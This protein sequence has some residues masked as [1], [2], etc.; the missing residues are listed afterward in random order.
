MAPGPLRFAGLALA[1]GCWLIGNPLV[2]SADDSS[3][4]SSG[5]GGSS[6]SVSSS[7]AQRPAVT[8]PGEGGR[9]RSG[10]PQPSQRAGLGQV[11][12]QTVP[13]TSSR[14]AGP[15]AAAV[16]APRIQVRGVDSLSVQVD[17]L[18]VQMV[19]VEPSS[20]SDAAPGPL[21]APPA[22][23]S[24]LPAASA[25][26]VPVA[27]PSAVADSTVTSGTAEVISALPAVSASGASAAV[28]AALVGPTPYA[29]GSFAAQL[30]ADPVGRS[31]NMVIGGLFDA[32]ANWVSTLPGGGFQE[33]LAG[34]L[35]LARRGWAGQESQSLG[36]TAADTA[37]TAAGSLDDLGLDSA[38]VASVMEALN[39]A[40][41]NADALDGAVPEALTWQTASMV[42]NMKVTT[43][44]PGVFEVT[45]DAP[46][47][48]ELDDATLAQW[49]IDP[50]VEVIGYKVTMA[51]DVIDPYVSDLQTGWSADGS[52]TQTGTGSAWLAG[53][54]DAT[55]S[56][57]Y[58]PPVSQ[59]FTSSGTGPQPVPITVQTPAT[60][61]VENSS[62]SAG[63]E[64]ASFF[65]AISGTTMT[66]TSMISG[67]RIVAGASVVSGPPQGGLVRPVAENTLITG[68]TSAVGP[69]K[70]LEGA[71]A[72]TPSQTLS[73][74]PLTAGV[75]GNELRIPVASLHGVTDL[76]SLVGYSVTGTEDLPGATVAPGTTITGFAS[77]DGTTAVFTVSTSNMVRA[78]SLTLTAPAG[79][80]VTE[81]VFQGV[82]GDAAM[83][84]PG[85]ALQLELSPDWVT[86]AG[87]DQCAGLVGAT[88]S[89]SGVTPATITGYQGIGSE[90]GGT[91]NVAVYQISG[92]PQAVY[93]TSA[94]PLLPVQIGDTPAADLVGRLIVGD[95]IP[96]GTTIV[97]VHSVGAAGAPSVFELSNPVTVAADTTVATV[98]AGSDPAG[99]FNTGVVLAQV[100]VDGSTPIG[101]IPG[102]STVYTAPG[103]QSYAFDLNWGAAGPFNCT[104]DK[105]C[106][107]TLLGGW[108]ASEVTPNLTARMQFEVTPV[109]SAALPNDA[110]EGLSNVRFWSGI[111]D[112][113]PLAGLFLDPTAMLA[114]SDGSVW[115]SYQRSP[116]AKVMERVLHA[117]NPYAIGESTQFWGYI[118]NEDGTGPGN[119]LTVTGC[120][121]G[122]SRQCDLA[123]G[124]TVR[125]NSQQE[126]TLVPTVTVDG[127]TQTQTWG[128]P[129]FD[130]VPVCSG[131]TCTST[132]T[133]IVVGKSTTSVFS[134]VFGIG[135]G[136]GPSESFYLDYT[137][138]A[139]GSGVAT[140]VGVATGS[141]ETGWTTPVLLQ[142][143]PTKLRGIWADVTRWTLGAGA[144]I[145]GN[146][147]EFRKEVKTI[148]D[149]S[150]E[151]KAEFLRLLAE[152]L[153]ENQV[154]QYKFVDGKWQLAQSF[155]T[156]MNGVNGT[157]GGDTGNTNSG[158]R[159]VAVP[160]ALV[161]AA[162]GQIFVASRGLAGGAV[163]PNNRS[164]WARFSPGWSKQVGYVHRLGGEEITFTGSIGSGSSGSEGSLPG[165]VLTVTEMGAGSNPI[166][167]GQT[168][169]A[170][171]LPEG[172]R[173]MSQL[174]YGSEGLKVGNAD[175]RP[176]DLGG[177]GTYLIAG[178]PIALDS[179]DMH[180]LSAQTID[181]DGSATWGTMAAAPDGTLWVG[182]NDLGNLGRDPGIA[183]LVSPIVG[184]A[185]SVKNGALQQLAPTADGSWTTQDVEYTFMHPPAGFAITET[186][187]APVRFVGSISGTT[188]TVTEVESGAV[189]DANQLVVG[190]GL[191][192]GQYITGN[193]V[194]TGTTI[195]KQLSG[196]TGG[197]GTYELSST[198]GDQ[199]VGGSDGIEMAADT[200][201]LWV[202]D[203]TANGREFAVPALSNVVHLN[204]SQNLKLK[205]TVVRI[206]SSCTDT[207]CGN[208]Q[209]VGR[210][211]MGLIAVPGEDAVLVA[212]GTTSLLGEVGYGAGA[213][214]CGGAEICGT[215]G[216]LVGTEIS[217]LWKQGSG[218][219]KEVSYNPNAYQ[220][221]NGGERTNGLAFLT[222]SETLE[223]PTD[224]LG[225]N[226]SLMPDAGRP[227][228]LALGPDGS[229]YMGGRGAHGAVRKADVASLN[230]LSYL[231][232]GTL[233]TVFRA[234]W[235][236][237]EYANVV[238]CVDFNQCA[239]DSVID[240]YRRAYEYKTEYAP[241]FVS[242]VWTPTQGL[243]DTPG[244]P[245]EF[246]SI[247]RIQTFGQVYPFV[248]PVTVDPKTGLPTG[249]PEGIF[250]QNGQF[251]G[252]AFVPTVPGVPGGDGS[253]PPIVGNVD[254]ESATLSWQ[255]PATLRGSSVISYTARAY[256]GDTSQSVTTSGTEAA[257]TGLQANGGTTYFTVSDTNV[258][259]TSSTANGQVASGQLW[260]A[261][262]GTTVLPTEGLGV[263]AVTDGTAF[264]NGGFDGWGNAYS[265]NAI[266]GSESA[267]LS[268]NGVSFGLGRVAGLAT[269]GAGGSQPNQ[270][271]VAR[272]AGQT[273]VLSQSM[274]DAQFDTSDRGVYQA[275]N[276]LNL[277]GAAANG[278]QEQVAIR[279]NYTDGTSEIWEQSFSDW[280]DPGYF[281]NEAI[282]SS[283]GYR[284]T[285]SGGTDS[286]TTYVYGYSHAV[287]QGKTLES[288]TLPVEADVALLGLAM[289]TAIAVSLG[290]N[291]SNSPLNTF[292][293]TTP[294]WQVANHQ[295][296]DGRGNYY[297]AFDLNN[298]SA[299][300]GDVILRGDAPPKE[301]MMSW[302]GSTFLVGQ[303]PT[304]NSEVGGKQG[305]RNVVQ[306]DGQTVY[307][308]TG[309][310]THVQLIG[311]AANGTQSDQ[312]ITVN[313]TDG[314]SA[315]WTQTFSDWASTPAPGSVAGEV[316]V[317]GGT[318]VNQ[319]GN[320]VNETANV[321]GYSYE[322]PEG[323]TVQSLV[324][325]SGLPGGKDGSV[326]ILGISLVGTPSV[327]PWAGV[328]IV[329]DGTTVNAT[330]GFDGSGNSYS[331]NLLTGSDAVGTAETAQ[332]S[333]ATSSFTGTIN[334][335]VAPATFTGSVSSGQSA[336]LLGGISS[337]TPGDAGTTLAVFD[338]A[339]GS[340]PLAVGQY[341][342]GG[343][344]ADGTA[345][346]GQL[347]YGGDGQLVT[348]ATPS[349]VLGGVGTY[350]VS[351][352]QSVVAGTVIEASQPGAVLVIDGPV[353]GGAQ[354]AGL[355]KVGESCTANC[356]VLLADG[357]AAGT[358]ITTNISTSS[359]FT[360]VISNGTAGSPGTTLTVTSVS[361]ALSPLAVGQVITGTG[362]VAGTT[363]TAQASGIA[364]GAGTYTLS[365]PLQSVDSTVMTAT[366]LMFAL[367]G[368]PQWIAPTTAMSAAGPGNTL[369]VSDVS[370]GA[371][372][373][374]QT[375][376]ATNFYTQTTARYTGS[377]NNGQIATFVGD[378]S[379]GTG[380]AGT[381]LSVSSVSG[382]TPIAV[383][384][385]L[386]GSGVTAGTEI[387]AQISGTT[388]GVGTYTVSGNAQLVDSATTMS[389][390]QPGTTL[391]VTDVDTA[392]GA[393]LELGQAVN[394]PGIAPGT[395]I[396]AFGTGVGGVGTY[397]LSGPP[398]WVAPSTPMTTTVPGQPLV[399]DGTVI[400]GQLSG[401]PG[402]AGVYT[403]SGDP[404]AVPSA[405]M[406]GNTKEPV[407]ALT[408]IAPWNGVEFVIGAPNQPNILRGDAQTVYGSYITNNGGE[409][410]L[411][412]AQ[413]FVE[414]C[415]GGGCVISVAAAGANGSQTGTQPGTQL[416]L[417]INYSDGTVDA[418]DQ[419]YSDWATPV[420]ISSVNNGGLI[421]PAGFDYSTYP[422]DSTT[423]VVGMQSFP[424]E[425]IIAS[426]AYRD[427]ADGTTAD[428]TTYVYGYSYWVPEGKTPVS[429]TLP[430]DQD[431]GVLSF[432][433]TKPTMVDLGDYYNTFGITTAP[434]QVGNNQ[435]YDGNG[436]YY[437]SSNLNLE[438][439]KGNNAIPEG[440][441]SSNDD[442]Q[443]HMTWAGVAFQVGPIPTNN[444]QVGG[445]GGPKNIVQAAGQ[446]I[447]VNQPADGEAFK[448]LY[449]LGAG[450]G[451]QVADMTVHYT[452]GTSDP[453]S[454]V[455]TG[456]TES[457][458]GTFDKL[459][460][461]GQFLVNA[462]T[463]INQKGNQTGDPANVFG[464]LF[465]IPEGKTVE[466]LELP[467]NRNI[468]ILGIS[469]L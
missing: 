371:I 386:S 274:V 78:T 446:T 18:S 135:D 143:T 368:E 323:M 436:N 96:T 217:K 117:M 126:I 170:E 265:W 337:G 384:Q 156:T 16:A 196:T 146:L 240:P 380:K 417:T 74:G 348:A 246:G 464:Y 231:E 314:T 291:V 30:E 319:L 67:G 33:M 398:Q 351:I 228:S 374:G 27:A 253:A 147:E 118:S 19:P 369:T 358:T 186:S 100:P 275:V 89:G 59:S 203:S 347:T 283:Q 216:S 218:H 224:W 304:S 139:K 447:T 409:Q 209:D 416:K 234:V 400:T 394:G 12:A 13:S 158:T 76:T 219:I 403:V 247:P 5:N 155:V 14:A 328:G 121:P 295:G 435:G 241:A 188:L 112:I 339:A 453:W 412:L 306:A 34:A 109:F 154:R 130:T 448:N 431:V 77:S 428:V 439:A 165:V 259:G 379:D 150:P 465:A 424:G 153:P 302:A 1:A 353:S 463:Q 115:V 280:T 392:V 167:V 61:A 366:Q 141:A 168:L 60:L 342:T 443:I 260:L 395:T 445:K 239:N 245:L 39:A 122:G 425:W 68:Q 284:N 62:I 271:N 212:V 230:P 340:A 63:V 70:G 273:L 322:I 450:F 313:F 418:I 192:E 334:S 346:T 166:V 85:A 95:G 36:V 160:H 15:A 288:V 152:P 195:G 200:Y 364:G 290:Q 433:A 50:G 42:T 248:S 311:A 382:A 451:Y 408:T 317:N 452:D 84:G 309:D 406:S 197:V 397:T 442:C 459:P 215:G 221:D 21:P 243:L 73:S 65:G 46:A 162:D 31:I 299:P 106:K 237:V 211:A 381:T 175:Q 24:T 57:Q 370:G 88:I 81:S 163:E 169:S 264:T 356:P 56:P 324:L 404:Q 405:P 198:V 176:D 429:I 411:A 393:A 430:S 321:Y 102:L 426:Q 402:G 235:G 415:T 458:V 17:S 227:Q 138:L 434:W 468:N 181:L 437:N 137:P 136:G 129:P 357:I 305:P 419:D 90:F 244:T 51:Q 226:E 64:P 180:Q 307:M 449:L 261:A 414:A 101:V 262:D 114:A 119:V 377:V 365:G 432:A 344:V 343:Q 263:G 111:E 107:Q 71:Y 69:I 187:A 378:I 53:L 467:D 410:V 350:T 202:N 303:I 238:A 462:G 391:T 208:R 108:I 422:V 124:G 2:A 131:N 281:A 332:Q 312:T 72:V 58:A 79:S 191:Y 98:Y 140:P 278:A 49:G 460:R 329:T 29:P 222:V 360:G 35:L 352:A 270:P 308:P 455:M 268:W 294:P 80:A 345:I 232:L 113:D 277:A 267:T 3:R 199:T 399:A 444:N 173:I 159:S 32:A 229:I 103:T 389:A 257:F 26:A 157:G 99:P 179:R 361:N 184:I 47:L 335:G 54:S 427:T 359:A 396:A 318:R 272:F 213:W 8:R 127:Q 220:A 201:A 250:V 225:T 125:P 338:V 373:V 205:S 171:G 132:D 145:T 9:T 349:N 193:G 207:G 331:W 86:A 287:A 148:E 282:I 254:G 316:V 300:G 457:M 355:A 298:M 327:A 388:G 289:S 144:L 242:Q 204:N 461:Q 194:A 438:W 315:T 421:G 258:L 223:I 266:P 37:A 172:T 206:D 93:G 441:S 292:G 116:I 23:A 372:T 4:V 286:T 385:F 75:A 133:T 104:V 252:A 279:L 48:S 285:A 297:D 269:A 189:N 296:F 44:A 326:G 22:S 83:D 43:T 276:V 407:T 91:D 185:R 367:S 190:T 55:T 183:G 10:A 82:V 20:G 354:F 40:A 66:V 320:A 94:T 105:S 390:A 38:E 45:W 466:Y 310:Y 251:G 376:G 363:I 420:Y 401:T 454:Q 151:R 387:L 375:I 110:T 336:T 178:A 41:L 301:I 325:P 293:I 214:L 182:I 413:E 25:V 164:G 236:L 11:A 174:T 6:G 120:A 128:T 255:P 423:P 383:G 233:F 142:A 440:C 249:A 92:S 330:D 362:V 52:P 177:V 28:S 469:L 134:E 256:A 333:P 210:G 456:L 87:C 123:N 149:Y 341:L 97:G 7:S 161:E